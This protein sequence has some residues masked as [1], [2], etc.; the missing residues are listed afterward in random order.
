MPVMITKAVN[1]TGSSVHHR[2]N[3]LH[4]STFHVYEFRRH[5][6][7]KLN[8]Y[9]YEVVRSTAWLQVSRW[10]DKFSF[11][12]SVYVLLLILPKCRCVL[13]K[14]TNSQ[15]CVDYAVSLSIYFPLFA[16]VLYDPHQNY[17]ILITWTISWNILLETILPF[18][19]N[20]LCRTQSTN[21]QSRHRIFH[22]L[23]WN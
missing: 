22:L 16:R 6:P 2:T 23:K 12:Y 4:A 14:C 15:F 18:L 13:D 1:R 7:Q 20:M 21:R 9:Y 3:E 8:N 11:L 17:L 19:D 10:Q 5:C